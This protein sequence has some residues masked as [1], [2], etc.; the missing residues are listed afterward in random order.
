MDLDKLIIEAEETARSCQ[1]QIDDLVCFNINKVL[2]AFRRLRVADMHLQASTGYGYN[3]AGRTTLEDIYAQV[4]CAESALVRQQI[5]SGTHAI[6][7]A[8]FGVLLP[9]DELLS[10]GRPY[11]TLQKV[12]GSDLREPG[13]LR[14]LGVS[15]REIPLNDAVIDP[16]A[17]AAMIGPQTKMLCLQRSKGYDWRPSLSIDVIAGIV[18]AVKEK[19]PQ[20]VIFVDNCYGE[21][22]E[23]QEPLEAGADLIA[24]SLIKNPGGGIAPGG[25]YIAG[26]LDLVERASFRLTAPGV[27]KEIGP[28]LGSN[29]LYYQGFF[30]APQVVGEA[31]SGAVF[32]AALFSRLGMEVLPAADEAR[33]DI[34]QAIKLGSRERVIAFCRE[35]QRHSPVDSHV[36]PEPWAM[37]G[38]ENQ[39]IMAAG[40]F[41]QGSSIELSADA[42]M[43]EPYI[44]YLQGGLS[45]HHVKIAVTA[46]ARAM[47]A[48]GMI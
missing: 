6:S 2:A 38:Y 12:I 26:R 23:K 1:D 34:V 3:D 15:Y 22:V 5:V 19:H 4:F 35:I 10:L 39:V 44:V 11:D 30:L 33:A 27:G 28:S 25:G 9:G 7:L 47:L 42:P 17:V 20:V 48:A 13:T 41:V 32:A 37:P 18:R 31:L 24:G 14:E 36:S 21:F 29:R 16:Q 43:R 8:L 46:A 45:R 40:A